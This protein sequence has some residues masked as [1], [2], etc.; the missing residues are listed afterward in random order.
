MVDCVKEQ[1]ECLTVNNVESTVSTVPSLAIRLLIEFSA[2]NKVW[3][4]KISLL[5]T[6]V[7]KVRT[8]HTIS[9]GI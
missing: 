8:G 7:S 3:V 6:F 9:A 4:N 1:R 5:K 2:F